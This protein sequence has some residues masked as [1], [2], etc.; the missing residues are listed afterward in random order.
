ME[1]KRKEFAATWAAKREQLGISRYKISRETGVSL[2][3]ISDI[4]NGTNNYTIDK[5]LLYTEFIRQAEFPI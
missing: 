4:E 2:K 1:N 5:F 3:I